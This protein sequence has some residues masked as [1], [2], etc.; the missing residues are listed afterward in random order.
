MT[1]GTPRPIHLVCRLGMGP[2]PGLLEW[3]LRKRHPLGRPAH[4]GARSPDWSRG[5]AGSDLN[6]FLASRF[7]HIQLARADGLIIRA[8]LPASSCA[9]AFHP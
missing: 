7:R 6:D 9:T 3:A 5:L 4:A 8:L 2:G 1:Q